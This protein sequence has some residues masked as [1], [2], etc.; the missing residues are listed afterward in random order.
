MVSNSQTTGSIVTSL[1]VPKRA[2]EMDFRASGSSL[3]VNINGK[4][5]DMDNINQDFSTT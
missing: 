5:L 4:M 2:E 3:S 1:D